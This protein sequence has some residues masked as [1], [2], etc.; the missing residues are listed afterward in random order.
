MKTSKTRLLILLILWMI[1]PG[2]D[3]FAQRANG[4]MLSFNYE[5]NTSHYYQMVKRPSLIIGPMAGLIFTDNG[6]IAEFGLVS[7]RTIPGKTFGISLSYIT[8]TS[9]EEDSFTNSVEFSSNRVL[10]TTTNP[11]VKRT[12][13]RASFYIPMSSTWFLSIGGGADMLTTEILM[14]QRYFEYFGELYNSNRRLIEQ[15]NITLTEHSWE[16]VATLG[17]KTYF[18]NIFNMGTYVSALIKEDF[19]KNIHVGVYVSINLAGL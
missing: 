1:Y 5:E 16:P 19:H 12:G 17:L 13:L 14:T 6:Y 3:L 10:E 15:T 7:A 18:G 11:E 8:A 2:T 9:T 4:N